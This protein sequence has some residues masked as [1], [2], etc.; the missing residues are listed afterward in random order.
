MKLWILEDLTECSKYDMV[1][2]QVVRAAT[3]GRARELADGSKS[4]GGDEID[5]NDPSQASC[6]EL[7]AAGEEEVIIQDVFEA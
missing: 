3:E 2:S 5:W 1:R 6:E 7:A 4:F